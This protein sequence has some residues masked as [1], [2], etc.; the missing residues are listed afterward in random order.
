MAYYVKEEK[1]EKHHVESSSLVVSPKRTSFSQG[2]GEP[3][4][5]VGGF[6]ALTGQV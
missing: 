1:K 4:G 5:M 6:W 3:H 2:D